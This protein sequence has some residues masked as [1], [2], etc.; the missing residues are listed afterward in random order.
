MR[1]QFLSHILSSPWM[2]SP[3]V[4]AVEQQ[5]LRG[6]FS[7]F[8]FERGEEP[9]NTRP[10]QVSIGAPSS[11][12]SDKKVSIISLR[13]TVLKHD[14][15]CGPVGTRT[16]ASRL[17]Q[18]DADPSV[19]AH[20][21]ICE[22][23]GGMAAA[24][25]EL[26][27]VISNLKKPIVAW[28]DGMACSAAMYIISYCSEIIASR[29]NDMIGCIGTMIQFQGF[30]RYGTGN[31]GLITA[32]IYASAATEKNRDYEDAL[33]G[34]FELVRS[35]MLDPLN[36]Q[37]VNA[38]K[39]NRPNSRPEELSG[40]T[41]LASAVVGTLIDSIGP[42]EFAITRAIE[43]A[44]EPTEDNS[45]N[46]INI[47]TMNLEHLNAIASVTGL[48]VEDGSAS[49][50]TE[51]LSDINSALASGAEAIT[52]RNQLREQV[53]ERERTIAQKDERISELEAALGAQGKTPA[54]DPAVG[55]SNSTGPSPVE[56][57]RKHLENFG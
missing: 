15:E 56:A 53:S 23:G 5:L 37:F 20:V 17:S 34:K 45:P 30:P 48:V 44:G 25:P 31:S 40:K 51:Q 2:I 32:R 29:E 36:D 14:A 10:Y 7:G 26:T 41:F 39:T 27:E 8:N 50:N 54:A 55:I 42:L 35:E 38:I 16:L 52:E 47:S 6:L 57:C 24:V 18:A 11:A 28:V 33:E 19:S 49:L 12:S 4:A 3:A 13:G 9:A 21:L 43:L 22:S 46:Q 1:Y